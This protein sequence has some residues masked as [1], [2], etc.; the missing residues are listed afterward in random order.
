[1]YTCTCS[2]NLGVACIR[3]LTWAWLASDP[4]Y[5][6]LMGLDDACTQSSLEMDSQS[7]P[8][9]RASA[10]ATK[11]QR[12]PGP[13]L[14]LAANRTYVCLLGGKLRDAVGPE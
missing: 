8:C 1:M 3:T 12:L 7:L 9:S 2:V 11:F 14:S 5:R 6:D 4:H 10:L 13:T